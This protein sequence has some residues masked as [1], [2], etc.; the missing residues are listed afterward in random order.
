MTISSARLSRTLRSFKDL[1]NEPL[2]GA[3]QELIS[4]SEQ[5]GRI[6][7]RK[8]DSEEESQEE[9]HEGGKES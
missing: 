7:D 6:E 9:K 3:S 8:T 4:L 2:S 1:Y 5:R